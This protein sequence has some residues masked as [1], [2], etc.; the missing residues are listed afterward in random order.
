MKLTTKTDCSGE[1]RRR[2]G[3]T[4][5][6]ACRSRFPSH[7]PAIQRHRKN[8]RTCCEGPFAEVLRA[9]GPMAKA[10][11]LRFSTKYQDDETGLLY[12]GYR[13]YNA[14]TGR[15]LSR[16]PINEAGQK[17]IAEDNGRLRVGEELNLYSFVG[18][19]P[20]S[21][22]DLL[23]KICGIRVGQAKV[24]MYMEGGMLDTGCGVPGDLPPLVISNFN[25]TVGHEWLEFSDGSSWGFGPW[26]IFN[27]V[28]PG[29][30]QA[31]GAYQLDR[32]WNTEC[33]KSSVTSSSVSSG[34]QVTSVTYIFRGHLMRGKGAIKP[35]ACAS[36][37]EITDCLRLVANDWKQ[38]HYNIVTRNCHDFVSE[39]L[40]LCGLKKLQ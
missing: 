34:N 8:S 9:S 21:R 20:V 14:S 6:K 17:L 31:G 37:D 39:A 2:N 11:P 15:W 40:S 13:Y 3:P 32:Y 4:F 23:G 35:C 33:A 10:N 36:C 22:W 24:R 28:Y 25:Y 7:S 38:K 1:C 26:D 29:V 19:L 12:Y 18:N 5:R 16:D 27:D 30:L